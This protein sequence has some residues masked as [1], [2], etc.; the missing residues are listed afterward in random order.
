M[1]AK[2]TVTV[3]EAERYPIEQLQVEEQVSD[4]IHSGTCSQMGWCRGKEV[5]KKE[6]MAAVATFKGSVAGRRSHA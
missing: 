4:A 2:E 6:Y 1:A 5:T 3:K